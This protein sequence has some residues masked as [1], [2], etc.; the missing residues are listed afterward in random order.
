MLRKQSP[1][2]T[3]E[4]IRCKEDVSK[5]E[6]RAP[7]NMVFGEGSEF[8]CSVCSEGHGSVCLSS[9]HPVLFYDKQSGTS[10]W[11]RR[12]ECESLADSIFNIC[13]ALNYSAGCIQNPCPKPNKA[14]PHK[15]FQ[16]FELRCHYAVLHTNNSRC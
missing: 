1:M 14:E 11:A 13:Y 5:M 7:L 2:K 9:L 16:Q 4:D 15:I 12:C 10:D 3:S 8:K 6:V